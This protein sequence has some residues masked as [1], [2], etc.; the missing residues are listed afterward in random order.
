[1]KLFITASV[2]SRFHGSKS[3]FLLSWLFR[4]CGQKVFF[5]LLSISN[6]KSTEGIQSSKWVQNGLEMGSKWA[7]NVPMA[8]AQMATKVQMAT[9]IPTATK[10][11]MAKK[12]TMA[13]KL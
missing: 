10:V 4:F 11:P 3:L 1:M 13:T 2:N 5:R 8:N 6:S 12:V 7:R 9:K